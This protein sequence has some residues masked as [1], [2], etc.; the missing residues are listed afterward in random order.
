MS[1]LAA[2]RV[3]ARIGIGRIAANQVKWGTPYPRV[4][5]IP[6]NP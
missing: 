4:R 6:P 3:V 2:A 5:R 1:R